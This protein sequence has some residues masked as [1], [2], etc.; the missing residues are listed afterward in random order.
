MNRIVVYS[1]FKLKEEGYLTD[2]RESVYHVQQLQISD[3][4]R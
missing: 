1:K 4:F 3:V 2:K